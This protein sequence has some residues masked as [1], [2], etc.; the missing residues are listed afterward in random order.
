MVNISSNANTITNINGDIYD[1]AAQI[2]VLKPLKQKTKKL[3]KD[4]DQAEANMLN[5]QVTFMFD[6]IS[7]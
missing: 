6:I 2:E 5:I 1:N 3:T 4:L 7:E